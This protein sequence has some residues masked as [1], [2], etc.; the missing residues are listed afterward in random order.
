MVSKND[1][2]HYC[3]FCGSKLPFMTVKEYLKKGFA[4]KQHDGRVLYMCDWCRGKKF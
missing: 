2:P 3:Q 1:F 4:I